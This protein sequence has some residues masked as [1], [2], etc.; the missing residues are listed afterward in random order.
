MSKWM[1]GGGVLAASVLILGGIALA[2]IL[3][4]FSIF[5]GEVVLRNTFLAKKKAVETSHDT[6][7]K[8]ISQKYNISEDYKDTFIQGLKAVAAGRE[9]GSLFK[10]NTE[11]SAQLGLSTDIFMAMMATIEG[12]RAMLKRE[13]DS[14]V[15]VWREHKTFCEKMPNSFLLSGKALPEPVMI[16][17]SRT[18][19]AVETGKDDDV[20][21]GTKH[22]RAG[23]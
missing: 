10:M 4:V 12:Q 8:V 13:Q 3:W 7:W 11:S 18:A 17:S 5:N 9:G 21:L 15:D 16:T 1:I 2:A 19:L 20:S 6:V 23:K 22:P 14:L